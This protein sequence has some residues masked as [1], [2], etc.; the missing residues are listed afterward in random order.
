LGFKYSSASRYLLM[1]HGAT[2]SFFR[3][4]GSISL[5]TSSE[6]KKRIKEKHPNLDELGV[7]RSGI[8][9]QAEIAKQINLIWVIVTFVLTAILS[10]TVFYLGQ[11]L[12][13]V[14]WQHEKNMYLYKEALI[15]VE[16]LEEKAE[17]ITEAILKESEDYAKYISSLQDAHGRMLIIVMM[18]LLLSFSLFFLRYQ[19]IISLK[20]CIDSAYMEQEKFLKDVKESSKNIKEVRE[21]R[22]K[23]KK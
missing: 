4:F 10:P 20:D 2:G 12:K 8:T 7:I 15:P 9:T 16:S 11:G 17:Y 22:L 5:N 18:M 13:P 6:L 23:K 3:C 1:K 21:N 14:D 19:W